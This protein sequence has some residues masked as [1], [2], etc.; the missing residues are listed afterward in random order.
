MRNMKKITILTCLTIS[1]FILP[2]LSG[3]QIIAERPESSYYRFNKKYSRFKPD[4]FRRE[5][6][7]LEEITENSS[8]SPIAARA[9]LRLALL[10][11]DYKNPEKNY[12]KAGIALEK[13]ISAEP[14]GAKLVEV[15]NWVN[16]LKDLD[17]RETEIDA[18]KKEIMQSSV[19][20]EKSLKNKEIKFLREENSSLK[21]EVDR[22][23]GDIEKLKSDIEKLS[24]LDLELEKKRKINR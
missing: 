24:R 14:E 2:L 7:N 1:L 3:C 19:G 4:G 9:Y 11:L 18:L 15:K 21:H 8:T 10:Y 16:V 6:E 12:K 5:M 22:L 13:Y 20:K 23:R 17:A